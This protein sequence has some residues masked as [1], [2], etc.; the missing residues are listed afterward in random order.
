MADIVENLNSLAKEQFGKGVP[1]LVPEGTKLQK[2]LPL[3]QKTPELGLKYVQT[4]RLSLPSGFTEALGDGTAGAFSLKDAVGGVQKRAEVTGAQ[5]LLK[6]Q[7]SL[8]DAAKCASSTAAFQEGTTFFFKGI[9]KACRRRVESLLFHGGQGIGTVNGAP[10]TSGSNKIISITASQWASGIWSG[11]EGMKLD[12]YNGSSQI[13]TNAPVVLVSVD[14]SGK[15]ITVSGNATDLGN[16]ANGH[17]LYYE[18]GYGNEWTGI[19]GILNNT[20][21]LFSIDA[22]AYSLWQAT[23]YAPTAGALSFQKMKK[24]IS[25]GVGKGLEEGLTF[26][27]SPGAWDDL[28]TSIE[29]VRRTN[30]DEVAK[31]DVGTENIVF[32][33]QNGSTEVIA[34]QYVKEGFAYGLCMDYWKRVGATDVTMNYPGFGGQMFFPLTG[35]AGVESRAYTHQAI[36]C[37]APGPNLIISNIVNT[38][39]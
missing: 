33:S 15:K 21:S 17:T 35:K 7:M 34:S 20:G 19:H 16:I 28:A 22:S 10:T 31:V 37:E 18:G 38:T 11:W 2:L 39:P 23:Q 27:V 13:N 8:E 32:H 5:V 36:F 29:A 12:V 1:D 25:L 24:A 3:N 30:K 4:V 26:F 6:D 9:Q 14:I